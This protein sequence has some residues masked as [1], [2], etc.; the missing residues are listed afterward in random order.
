MPRT[1]DDLADARV[2]RPAR[3]GE[4]GHFVT[5]TRVPARDRRSSTAP[6]AGSSYWERL[7]ANDVKVVDGWEQAYD[8]EF[9]AGSGHGDRPA[10]RELRVESRRP[11]SITPT[12]SR[13]TAPTGALTDTCFRQVELA[14][15]L[16]GADHPQAARQLIDFMLSEK[17]QA[18]I[19]LQMFVFPAR[20]GTPLPSVFTKFATVPSDPANAAAGGDRPRSATTGSSSGPP[21]CCGD[22]A[23]GR[24]ALVAVPV[25][26][27]AVF[28][29]WPVLAIIGRGLAPDGALNLDPLGEV[30]T[31]PALRHVFWFTVWQAV[32]STALTLV[33]GAA[34]CIRAEPVP[35]PGP[36]AG[37]RARR[38]SRSC[39]RR[40]SSAPRSAPSESPARSRRS[41]SRTC[42][43][44]TRSSSAPSAGSGPTSTLGRKRPRRSSA[45]TGGGRSSA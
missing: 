8:S 12:R 19:P 32:L 22:R 20:A 11:R 4:P 44:T 14:G 1:L 35:L 28:F 26:F 37:A 39:C 33:L 13:P 29:A 6:T 30:L 3:G 10:R 40:W 16:R 9:S 36:G 42:S 38:P 43:S 34:G 5:R 31:D 45:R 17:F 2:P 24:V 25:G 7:R 18:D 27:L 15:V 23:V 21:P 41:C